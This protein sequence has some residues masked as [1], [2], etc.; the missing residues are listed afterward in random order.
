[1]NE[2]LKTLDEITLMLRSTGNPA[3]NV[4]KLITENT[5]LRRTIERIQNTAAT[6]ARIELEHKAVA[7]GICKIYSG[8]LEDMPAE[9]L[10]NIA[11]QIRQSDSNSAVIIG[12]SNEGKASLLVSL[13]DEVIKVSGLSAVEIIRSVS[14]SIN[15][16]GG[17]QSF[18]ATA[19]GKRPEGL[20]D[21]VEKA[22]SL[23]K[24]AF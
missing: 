6:V 23:V 12:S 1:V 14:A 16:G 20:S 8:V 3:A 21:A 11:H 15:G 7:V 24:K 4:S 9:T 17:G 10:K 5:S 13:G 22:V 2:K 18:L 19:G